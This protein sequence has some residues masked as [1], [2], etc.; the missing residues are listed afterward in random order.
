MYAADTLGRVHE[1]WA[2]TWTASG[3]MATQ[4]FQRRVKA[5]DEPYVAPQ[6]VGQPSRV[7]EAFEVGTETIEQGGRSWEAT[8]HRWRGTVTRHDGEGN[9]VGEPTDVASTV[10]TAEGPLFGHPLRWNLPGREG[11]SVAWYQLVGLGTDA[12]PGVRLPA[13]TDDD[14]D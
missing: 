3:A 6:L 12:R 1:A 13:G 11:E 7:G 4:A 10:W 2:S 5:G 14:D 9:L 8:F